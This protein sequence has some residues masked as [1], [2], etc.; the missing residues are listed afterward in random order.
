MVKPVVLVVVDGYGLRDDEDGNAV[1]AADTPV[2]DNLF[3]NDSWSK[4]TTS[5]EDVGLPE[6]QMGNSEVGHM[7][8]GAGRIVYQPLTRIDKAIREGDFYENDVLVRAVDKAVENNS[9]LHLFGLLSDG[10]VHS[11]QKHI[12]A[13]LEL[14][15]RRGLGDVAVHAQHDGRDVPP[16]AAERYLKKLDEY[17]EETGVGY[18]A[19]MG[20]RYYGMDR[21]NRW[22]RTEKAYRAIVEG[23]S[24]IRETDPYE[25]L[26]RAYEERAE[27]DEFITPTVF[28]DKQGGPRTTVDDGDSFLCFNFRPDRVRQMTR[29]LTEEE[30]DEFPVKDIDIA[31]YCMTEY[32]ETFDLPVAFP[33]LDLKNV[34]AEYLSS[35]GKKQFHTA[36][37]EKYAHVTFFFNGGREEPFDGEERKLVPSPQEVPTYDY[38]PEM[39][40][41]EVTDELVKRV[42]EE[43]DD[44]IV[45]NYA[46]GDMVGHTGDF[47]AT[48]K[49]LQAVDK[50]L[51]RL[52]EAVRCRGG[53]MLITSDHGNAE[54][55]K[56]PEENSPHTAHTSNPTPL[57]YVGER[58]FKLKDG[59]LADIA[60]T[61]L[62]L[63][64]LDIPEEMTGDVLVE[65]I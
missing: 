7:N 22:E 28:T 35:Q 63:M 15:C 59:K 37:T 30:F 14:A 51:G 45:V 52:V 20:G 13:L 26:D 25:A 44:F 6:G 29:A 19:T 8:I 61:I 3:E 23:K 36:E 56:D 12:K 42:R 60:P 18:L 34:L 53:E 50:C 57:I 49:A 46:N 38:K 17:F 1:K 54:I 10:G 32:D 33:P 39:S 47:E 31:Y 43:D 24:E 58:N 55:M 5:G 2:L 64:G 11:H 27:D 65:K 16:R 48:V 4:M 21:D 62:T 9:T 41:Y 40:A